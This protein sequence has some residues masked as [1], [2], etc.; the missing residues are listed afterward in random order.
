MVPPSSDVTAV[1][2]CRPSLDTFVHNYVRDDASSFLKFR[3]LDI[4]KWR[5]VDFFVASS[6]FSYVCRVLLS[7]WWYCVAPPR[8]ADS[9]HNQFCWCVALLVLSLLIS[10]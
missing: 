8:F 1:Q 5:G 10:M 6:T 4:K 7:A 3:F 2:R 9:V